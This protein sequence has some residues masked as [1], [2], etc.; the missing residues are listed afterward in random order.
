MVLAGMRIETIFEICN[1]AVS[2]WNYQISQQYM[3]HAMSAKRA[4]DAIAEL[5][6][7]HETAVGKLTSKLKMLTNRMKDMKEEEKSLQQRIADLNQQLSLK[8]QQVQKLQNK[9]TALKQRCASGS[10][11]DYVE[12][13]RLHAYHHHHHHRVPNARPDFRM[14][15]RTLVGSDHADGCSQRV[16]T[17][18]LK[19]VP[20]AARGTGFHFEP[21]IPNAQFDGTSTL[22]SVSRRSSDG[23]KQKSK[24]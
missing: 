16:N 11:S 12:D 2:F 9:N 6:T 20:A 19:A 17:E 10:M 13:E 24:S 22:F 1:R 7:V 21:D 18:F 5:E 3:F 23:S 14:A 15:P 4:K 8:N